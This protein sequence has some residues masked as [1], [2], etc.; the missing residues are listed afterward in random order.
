MTKKDEKIRGAAQKNGHQTLLK[1]DTKRHQSEVQNTKKEKEQ[2][3]K[4]TEKRGKKRLKRSEL[5][6]GEDIPI[7]DLRQVYGEQLIN[8]VENNSEDEKITANPPLSALMEG[9]KRPKK[10]KREMKPYTPPT[11][12]QSNA[13][14]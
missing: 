3:E 6:F 11:I 8:D 4:M 10:Q 7:Q 14:K 5:W 13:D 1:N 12:T 2:Q 9:S